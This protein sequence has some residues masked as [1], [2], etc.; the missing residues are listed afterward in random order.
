MARRK[1]CRRC[2]GMISWSAIFCPSCGHL[3]VETVVEPDQQARRG[4]A[5]N[6]FRN[7]FRG[8]C[9]LLALLVLSVLFLMVLGG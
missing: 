2:G 6:V 3:Y 4:R 9:V 5:R 7:V 8:F 1:Q